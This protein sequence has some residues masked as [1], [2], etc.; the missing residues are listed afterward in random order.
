MKKIDSSI[1][2]KALELY[3]SSRQFT[4]TA[5]ANQLNISQATVHRILKR[6]NFKTRSVSEAKLKATAS[7]EQLIDLYVNQKKPCTD[8]AKE[9]NMSVSTVLRKVRRLGYEVRTTAQSLSGRKYSKAPVKKII[10]LHNELKSSSEISK[11]IEY[12]D[13][14]VLKVL[15]DNQ[16]KTRGNIF[17]QKK[18]FDEDRAKFLYAQGLS[19]KEVSKQV[20]SSE[21]CVNRF[22]L[23]SGL[24]K[25]ENMWLFRKGKPMLDVVKQKISATKYKNFRNGTY[26][27][28]YI[29]R[30]GLTY[31][32]YARQ[33]PEYKRYKNQV[34]SITDKQSLET[35]QNYEKRGKCGQPGAYQIDHRYS[36][37][38][39]FKNKVPPCIIANIINLE[40]LPWEQNLKKK[41]R[42]S[43]NLKELIKLIKI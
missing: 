30:T 1:E 7:S 24:N 15:K 32:Q 42:C 19:I 5:I 11:I 3:I 6:N 28:L 9:L 37:L 8:I 29:K 17:Y 16:V 40:M 12:S 26:D 14:L 33:L 39:G 41:D 20:N 4:T 25:P 2:N 23:K 18:Y 21:Y 31:N 38:S 27:Y 13:T 22:L 36:I 35:L 34:R 10:Q 43:I